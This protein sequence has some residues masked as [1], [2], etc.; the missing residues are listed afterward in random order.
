MKARFMMESPDAIE[1]TMKI[2]MTMK[3]WCDLRD[4]LQEKWPSSRL[5]NMITNMLGQARKV[6]YPER[7]V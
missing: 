1:A 5:S 6:F 2:T 4:Q 3:D 7:E